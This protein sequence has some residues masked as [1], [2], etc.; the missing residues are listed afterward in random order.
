M[1]RRNQSVLSVNGLIGLTAWKSGLDF[2]FDPVILKGEVELLLKD[3]NL[4]FYAKANMVDVKKCLPHD[5]ICFDRG[6]R[7][8]IVVI[9]F[10]KEFGRSHPPWSII[11]D[12]ISLKVTG[13]IKYSNGQNSTVPVKMTLVCSRYNVWSDWPIP[14]HHSLVTAKPKQKAI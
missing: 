11:S 8:A 10:W 12:S 7:V 14:G 3:I 9:L 13:K 6:I 5:W 4:N 1:E 2:I